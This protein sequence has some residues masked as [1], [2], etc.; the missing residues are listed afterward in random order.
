MSDSQIDFGFLRAVLM[1]NS[2]NV[3]D[4]SRD[5]LFQSRLQGIL[6]ANGWQSLDQLIAALRADSGDLERTV[7]EAMTINE[8]SFF[9]ENATFDL[10]RDELLPALIG[11]RSHV[12]TL[13]FWSAA[14][15]SGQEAYSIAMLIREHFPQ[16]AAWKI[17][18]QG[19]DLSSE[20]VEYARVGRYRSIEINR[21]LPARFLI[22]YLTRMGDAWEMK[23]EIKS[24]CHFRQHNLCHATRFAHKFDFILLRNVMI[25]FDH[26][27]RR[28]ILCNAHKTLLPDGALF[29]GLSEQANL[30]SCWQTVLT[31]KA[32]WYR[33]I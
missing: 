26:E 5:Y 8:T 10:L 29:L 24:M 1:R 16:L 23:P 9:R 28:Q 12:R 3:V 27:K 33:P 20:M 18:I 19:T 31:P 22:K 15:S 11:R 6:R 30:D 17:E 2:G 13:H 32:I 21:G 25:Y 14:S 4:A 7:A